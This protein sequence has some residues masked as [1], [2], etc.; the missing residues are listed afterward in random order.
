MKIPLLDLK[1]QYNSIKGELDAALAACVKNQQFVLGEEIENLE[2]EI[3]KYCKTRYGIG[4]A[5]G[6]D[7][8]FLSL[9]ALG[10]KEGDE[11]ITT[12]V[13]FIATAEAISNAGARPVFVDI[14]EKT[15]SIDPAAIEAK[16]T[17]KTKAIIPVHI[18]GQCV[19]MDPITDI[20]E[21][22]DLKIVEDC[23]QAIGSSYK[24]K[25]AGSMG[26]T[27]CLSFFPSKNLG[28]FGDGGMIVTSDK[29]LAEKLKIL[30]VHGSSVRYYHDVIG[31]NSRLDN[32]QAA[33]LRVKLKYLDKWIKAR[34]E[35]AGIYDALLSSA[36][37]TV[38]FVPKYNTHTYHLYII[39]TPLRDKLLKHLIG[40]GIGA[41]V[42]YPVPLHLQ[43]CYSMLGH[44]KGDFPISERVSDKCLA[45]PIYPELKKAD[46]EKI[47][48]CI[49]EFL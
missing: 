19:D 2:K 46:A 43:K 4:V 22:H 38:P 5:S 44:K 20:A 49:K 10:I 32:L 41:R 37:V 27:G 1:S 29:D 13:T 18:Y 3:A 34:Q 8:L 9:K 39:E 7:A 25:K 6:T 42:Y 16:I 35:I 33:V 11:V 23:A 26:H 45:I 15:S 30:R 48:N 21:K 36:D 31:Y 28:A 12:P 47:A 14:D 17:K 24:G 40:R